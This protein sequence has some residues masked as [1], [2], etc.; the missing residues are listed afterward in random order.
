[1]YRFPRSAGV[2]CH[3]TSLPGRWGIGDMGEAAYQFVDWL[4]RAGQAIWQVLPL[5]PPGYGESPY[6]SFSAFA[7]NPLL[8]GL[9][10]LADE[11]WLSRK[12]LE[13]AARFEAQTVDFERVQPFRERC[14]A[15]AFQAFQKNAS[16]AQRAELDAFRHDQAWWL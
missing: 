2:L 7:G 8:I 11:G 15:Q 14:L 1:M 6:Q 13:A 3:V 4:A 16:S 12:E 9:D 10:R 5:G